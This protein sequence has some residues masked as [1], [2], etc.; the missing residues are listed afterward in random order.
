MR[1]N[2]IIALVLSLSSQLTA[3]DYLGQYLKEGLGNNPSIKAKFSSY[4]AAMKISESITGLPDPSL[5]LG[6][7]ISPVETRLGA[8]RMRFSFNQSLPWFGTIGK[9]VEVKEGIAKVKYEEFVGEFLKVEWNIR[10]EYYGLFTIQKGI[11]Q[12]EQSEKLLKTLLEISETKLEAGGSMIDVLQLKMEINDLAYSKRS[13]RLSKEQKSADFFKLLNREELMDTLYLPDSLIIPKE[14]LL[15]SK[16]SFSHNAEI[17]KIE[18]EIEQLHSER[19]L[20]TKNGMPKLSLGVDYLLI[21]ERNDIAVS[22]NG[23]DALL[24]PKIG[25][26][27]PI[28]RKKYRAMG[29]A[30]DLK[31]KQK[32]DEKQAALNAAKAKYL[33]S[34]LNERDSRYRFSF[35]KN[36]YEL[37]NKTLDLLT[38]SYS[39]GEKDIEEVI[40]VQKLSLMYHFEMVKATADF[41]TAVAYAQFILGVS[42]KN[43]K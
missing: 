33:Y 43:L 27:L 19:D 39:T 18:K 5:G 10:S 1:R 13:L 14:F 21:E 7:F 28:Y 42:S 22:D 32:Y 6:Y 26:T 2:L 11:E 36:Q 12:V 41:K 15:W 17:A 38:N 23:K 31:I 30:I 25:I 3:Q 24:L 34:A 37:S 20:V 9:E 29:E 4:E 8:Q 16:D 40:R 35:Y